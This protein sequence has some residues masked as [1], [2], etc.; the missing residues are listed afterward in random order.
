MTGGAGEG[1]L[2]YG[3]RPPS[4][5]RIATPDPG[6]ALISRGRRRGRATTV[7]SEL[8]GETAASPIVAAGTAD[9]VVGVDEG[10]GAG[11]SAG[12]GSAPGMVERP[13]SYCDI[14]QRTGQQERPMLLRRKPGC[15]KIRRWKLH[16]DSETPER[17]KGEERDLGASR[18]ERTRWS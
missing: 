7:L 10:A 4:V 2:R 1:H 17:G 8:T 18:E 15:R 16:L 14:L 5:E 6:C 9:V 11:R 12:R 13:A 3:R